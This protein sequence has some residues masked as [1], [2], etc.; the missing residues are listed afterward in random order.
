MTRTPGLLHGNV[1]NA[2]LIGNLPA[3]ACVEVPCHV[4]R[5]GVQP[6]RIGELPVQL[7]ALN[8]V[9]LAV[10]ELTVRAALEGRR[11][12]VYQAA[13]LDPNTAATLPLRRVREL[14]DELI[15]AHGDLLPE[16]VWA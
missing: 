13:L 4:D 11:D 5:A 15:T 7:A 6:I 16:G 12:H 1:R 10:G 3:D 8:N 14:V 2:G 9:T